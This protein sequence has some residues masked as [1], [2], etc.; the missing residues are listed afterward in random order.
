MG[1]IGMRFGVDLVVGID[2][3]TRAILG[4][5]IVGLDLAIEHPSGFDQV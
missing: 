5:D 2:D 1:S 3:I 4:E